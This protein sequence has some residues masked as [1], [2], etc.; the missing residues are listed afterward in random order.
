MRLAAAERLLLLRLAAAAAAADTA[1]AA[2]AAT[3]A[4]AAAACLLRA[5]PARG[6]LVAN[7]NVVQGQ[8]WAMGADYALPRERRAASLST[9]WDRPHVRRQLDKSAPI[10]IRPLHDIAVGAIARAGVRAVTATA[11]GW[12]WQPP[13]AAPGSGRLRLS[14]A[15]HA[16]RVLLGKL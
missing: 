15:P 13:E 14:R 3:A 11:R 5:A 16:L 7:G 1:A 4:A 10:A 6:S 2:A 9:H 12:S 8:E